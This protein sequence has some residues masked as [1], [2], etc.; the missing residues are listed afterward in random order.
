M[1]EYNWGGAAS[2]IFW[3][4]PEKDLIGV[5][6]IQLLPS[7]FTTALQFKKAVYQALAE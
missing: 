5:Y 2:T 1:G 4:D 3:I 6:L 7:N